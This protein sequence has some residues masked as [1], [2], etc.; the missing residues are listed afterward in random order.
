MNYIVFALPSWPLSRTYTV[1]RWEVC[2]SKQQ[3]VM[4]VLWLHLY[5]LSLIAVI[6]L[7]SCIKYFS[8]TPPES[9]YEL[10]TIGYRCD[11]TLVWGWTGIS[12]CSVW[13]TRHQTIQILRDDIKRTVSCQMEIKPHHFMSGPARQWFQSIFGCKSWKTAVVNLLT[14]YNAGQLI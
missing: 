14:L 9:H 12:S 2:V 10:S 8:L 6:F 13:V 1:L 4:I 5:A 11:P 3:E 7:S